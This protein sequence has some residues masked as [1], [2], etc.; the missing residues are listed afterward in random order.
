MQLKI[1]EMDISGNI[2]QVFH[3]DPPRVA[4]TNTVYGV[5]N[6][7]FIDFLKVVYKFCLS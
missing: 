5:K 1:Y 7:E 6:Q 2:K 3:R 4:E